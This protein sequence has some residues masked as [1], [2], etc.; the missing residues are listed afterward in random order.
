L[1]ASLS[2]D[3]GDTSGYVP[4]E[5]GALRLP[6]GFADVAALERFDDRPHEADDATQE[7]GTLG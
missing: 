7:G 2:L 6:G 3:Q 5:R 4:P 1:K